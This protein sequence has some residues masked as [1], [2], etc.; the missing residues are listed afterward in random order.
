M[1][2]YG[3]AS[4]PTGASIPSCGEGEA[5]PQS[6]LGLLPLHELEQ[7]GSPGPGL[8]FPQLLAAQ[9]PLPPCSDT[10]ANSPV[11]R[12]VL[13]E[14]APDKAVGTRPCNR[15]MHTE[16]PKKGG[17]AVWMLMTSPATEAGHW[18]H[19]EEGAELRGRGDVQGPQ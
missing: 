19:W 5:G 3:N 6:T 14:T 16:T 7:Q 8:P 1:G 11:T 17:G 13:S 9:S 4:V 12:S 10:R 2:P 15:E 18:V